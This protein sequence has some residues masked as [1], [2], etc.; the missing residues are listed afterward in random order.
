MKMNNLNE[1]IVETDLSTFNRMC[2]EIEDCE[3]C[4]FERVCM[5]IS[6]GNGFD[7]M[8]I[9]I[10]RKEMEGDEDEED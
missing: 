4:L 7:K 8:T 5:V 2:K 9:T 1:L 10:V 3:N 6:S